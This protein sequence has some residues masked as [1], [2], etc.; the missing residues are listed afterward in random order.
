MKMYF[1]RPVRGGVLTLR[2]YM[3]VD[4]GRIVIKNEIPRDL[5][6]KFLRNQKLSKNIVWARRSSIS[7]VS[8]FLGTKAEA[9]QSDWID[10]E[11]LESSESSGC[12]FLSSIDIELFKKPK[13]IKIGW[14]LKEHEFFLVG[15]FR[16]FSIY[17][18]TN[19]VDLLR[20]RRQNSEIPDFRHIAKLKSIVLRAPM[21]AKHH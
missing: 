4:I 19:Q 11:S 17:F 5:G 21:I 13:I 7:S 6:L 20:K 16:E 9:L 10:L 3:F 12:I 8:S 15:G 14:K 1:E 18:L 2:R